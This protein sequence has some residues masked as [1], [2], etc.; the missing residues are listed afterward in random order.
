MNRCCP[1]AP[2]TSSFWKLVC[3][4]AVRRNV[5]LNK[6]KTVATVTK[7]SETILITAQHISTTVLLS[8]EEKTD[9]ART[10]A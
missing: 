6:I 1:D 9:D 3:T 8:S 5:S 2:D 10:C 7:L 4:G